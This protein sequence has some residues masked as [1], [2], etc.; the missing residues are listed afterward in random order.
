MQGSL[1]PAET[2]QGRDGQ[3]H[4]SGEIMLSCI[5]LLPSNETLQTGGGC[6]PWTNVFLFPMWPY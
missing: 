1:E 4:A 3:G 2:M 5:C 6:S